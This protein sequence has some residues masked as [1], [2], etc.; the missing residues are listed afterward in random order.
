MKIKLSQLEQSIEKLSALYIISGDETLL[1]QDAIALVRQRALAAGFNE[2]ITITLEPSM[3][4]EQLFH[5]NVYSFSLFSHKKIVEFNLHTTKL[6]QHHGKIL[7]DYLTKPDKNTL[8]L[9]QTH[10]IEPAQ[11]KTVW[12][13]ALEKKSIVVSV[14]PMTAAQ[15][16]HWIIEYAKKYQLNMSK[17]FAEQL[18]FLVEGNL[19]AAKQEIEKLSLQKIDVLDATTLY[20]N[21]TDHAHFDIFNL[22]ENALLGLSN[23]CLRILHHLFSSNIEPTLIL[24]ALMREIRLLATMQK[25]LLAGKKLSQ[26]LTEH[27]IWEKRQASIRSGLQR[28]TQTNL[29]ELLLIGAKI[30][31]IIKGVERGNS[32]DELQQ[33]TLKIAKNDIIKS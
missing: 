14:W 24:W 11:E 15:L 20:E 7:T 29:W 31:R 18:A 19:L 23:R 8:V 12:F 22:V 21:V 9:I 28:H 25:Q 10:K 17:P 2:R 1:V 32:W 33:L 5:A 16:P 30:D 3:S 4:F 13:Q 26:L 6:S 27:R